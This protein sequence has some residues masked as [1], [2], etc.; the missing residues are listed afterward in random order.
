MILCPFCEEGFM[1][2][3]LILAHNREA[4]FYCDVDKKWYFLTDVLDRMEKVYYRN[5]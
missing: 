1:T 2:S 3:A 5:K 4:W